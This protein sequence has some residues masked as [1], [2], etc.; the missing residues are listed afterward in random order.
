LEASALRH[1]GRLA[2]LS[3]RSTLLR[4]QGDERLIEMTRAGHDR[5]F[6]ALVDRYQSRLHAFCRGMLGSNEDAE[7]ILQEVFVAAHGAMLA[8][9]RPINARPWL[10]RIARNRCLNH[11]RKPVPEGQDSMDILPGENGVSVAERVQKREDFRALIS[12][13]GDLAETQRTALLL[14]EIDD[15]SYDEIAQAMDTTI[16]AVK[17]LLVRARMSLA[18]AT[19]GRKLTC[20]E[21]R[22]TLAE[23]AEGLRKATGAERS[24]IKGCDGCAEYRDQLRSN[25]RALAA[26]APLGTLAAIQHFLSAKLGIGGAK[27]AAGGAAGSTATAGGAGSV[28]AS[29]GAAAAGGSGFSIATS[30]AAGLVGTKA[31]AGMASVAILTAGAVEAKHYYGQREAQPITTAQVQAAPE[32]H[33]T[34]GAAD[35]KPVHSRHFSGGAVPATEPVAQPVP[36]ANLVPP[37]K[38]VPTGADEPVTTE[39]PIEA[40]SPV[41]TS[42]DVEPTP[43]GEVGDTTG[44]TGE[45]TTTPTDPATPTEPTTPGLPTDP[46]VPPTDPVPPPEPTPTPGGDAPPP[47]AD[48]LP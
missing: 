31:V 24:H 28:G 12:D 35:A 36:D 22:L 18:D 45:G 7:D 32:V 20:D 43:S 38:A 15:L 48:P 2:V 41:L 39:E 11:L 17:S 23:A 25:N 19:Q 16:P 5:A 47:P 40:A 1:S 21:V 27:G 37:A 29:A 33:F 34:G 30:G 26:M 44:G 8:D 14:R 42:A 3:K 6:E 9:A 46:T 13:V 10:Y 4:L